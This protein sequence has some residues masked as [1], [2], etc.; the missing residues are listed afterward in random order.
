MASTII[1]LSNLITNNT[2]ILTKLCEQNDIPFPSLNDPCFNPNS[3]AFRSIPGAANACNIIIAA[4]AQLSTIV[5]QP[6]VSIMKLA[7]AVRL[8][9]Y[10][11]FVSC[12]LSDQVVKAL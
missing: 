9:I 1:Q 6:N 8:K 2:A 7:D 3:D 10:Y 4:A 11:I 12:P 5:D